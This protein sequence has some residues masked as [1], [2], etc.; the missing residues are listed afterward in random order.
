MFDDTIQQQRNRYRRSN[1]LDYWPAQTGDVNGNWQDPDFTGNILVRELTSNGLSQSRSAKPPTGV[2]MNLG[3]SIN[4]VLGYDKK[5]QLCI[6]G[7]DPYAD[8]PQGINPL[9]AIA[10]A[11]STEVNQSQLATL[12]IMPSQ[13]PSLVVVLKGW[14]LILNGIYDPYDGDPDIDLTLYLPASGYKCYA[15]IFLREDMTTIDI[16]T[17][18]PFLIEDIDLGKLDVQE[19]L[20]AEFAIYATATPIYALTLVGDQTTITLQDIQSDGVELRQVVNVISTANTANMYQQDYVDR[21]ITIPT[22]F[23][24]NY[25]SRLVIGAGG[26][27][28]V[29]GRLYIR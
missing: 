10:L 27:I 15:A 22:K 26:R 18:T 1:N 13:P 8:L 11:N 4:V 14:N 19:C 23:Q 6:V 16:Q 20:D 5:G 21:T 17:S 2:S 9:T 7:P 3:P 12:A 25:A 24:G 28:I 29:N